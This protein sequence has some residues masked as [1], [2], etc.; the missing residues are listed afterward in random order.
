MTSGRFTEGT[1]LK[2]AKS[3]VD[4]VLPDVASES[5]ASSLLDNQ[6]GWT[7]ASEGATAATLSRKRG[8]SSATSIGHDDDNE[9][10]R[11]FKRFREEDEVLNST[12]QRPDMEMSFLS[13]TPIESANNPEHHHRS[14]IDTRTRV[15]CS[16]IPKPSARIHTI[17]HSVKNL[18]LR[19]SSRLKARA[20]ATYD[21]P[22]VSSR[23]PTKLHP[24]GTPARS[25]RKQS[26]RARPCS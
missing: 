2:W 4:S 22:K 6:I 14:D 26:R 23:S 3:S 5:S 8:S 10:A 12:Q 1:G 20:R 11:L 17:D 19:R 25:F 24:I 18:Y 15:A 9:G 7:T 13:L 16:E 21:P